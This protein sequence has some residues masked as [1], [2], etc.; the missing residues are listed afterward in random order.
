MVN[1]VEI[2]QK[3][4][5]FE[6]KHNLT[7]YEVL[8][9]YMFERILERISVSKYHRYANNIRF[10]EILKLLKKLIKELELEILMI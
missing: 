4:K 2:K 6:I 8:Q 3:V 7:H 10:N 5:E 1:N 9:R